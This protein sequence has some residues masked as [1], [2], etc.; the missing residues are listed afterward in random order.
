MLINL[1]MA[2]LTIGLMVSIS[3]AMS[4]EPAEEIDE[5]K[6]YEDDDVILAQHDDIDWDN[7][8]KGNYRAPEWN[9]TYT[10]RT[11]KDMDRLNEYMEAHRNYE[12]YSCN[13]CSTRLF[14]HMNRIKFKRPEYWF[15]TNNRR[16][17]IHINATKV[18]DD[19]MVVCRK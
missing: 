11:Q 12:Y 9:Q 18:I 1:W 10:D 19:N 16:L 7:F 5:P 3:L 15:Q 2:L 4:E 8:T 17:D 13:N 14:E 6:I